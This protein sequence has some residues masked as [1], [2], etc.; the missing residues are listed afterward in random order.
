MASRSTR[1]GLFTLAA[2]VLVL[3]VAGATVLMVRAI[4]GGAMSWLG[5]GA[6]VG[7]VVLTVALGVGLMRLSYL[8]ARSGH[9]D[10]VQTWPHQ[11]DR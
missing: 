7:G 2:I 8:S 9:D 6:M 10:A 5:I 3:A 4:S 1:T 11:R